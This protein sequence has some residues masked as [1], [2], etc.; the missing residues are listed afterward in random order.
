MT[1]SPTIYLIL[2][3]LPIL[4]LL[5]TMAETSAT[6]LDAII[7]STR[8]YEE[9]L[10]KPSLMGAGYGALMNF[11]AEP[12]LSSATYVVDDGNDKDHSINVYKIPL[13]HDF[14]LN[15]YGMGSFIEGRLGYL[16]MN[17]DYFLV[18]KE[19]SL[20]IVGSKWE[21]C[22]GT[23]GGGLSFPMGAGFSFIP[24]IYGGIAYLKNSSSYHGELANVFLKPVFD[25]LG[26]NWNTSATLLNGIATIQYADTIDTFLLN[27]E[28][29]Y[30]FDYIDTFN[31][32]SSYQKFVTDSSVITFKANLSHPLGFAV[33]G[34]PLSWVIHAGNSTFIGANRNVMGFNYFNELGFSIKADTAQ[35]KWSVQNISLGFM[36][37][38]GNNIQGWSILFGY[39][40]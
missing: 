10:L 1:F 21:T 3:F 13:R 39:S 32:S 24:A 38:L 7:A 8:A 16:K 22:S 35:K 30:S 27:G 25:G 15:Q 28:L 26:F 23:L 12:A 5:C 31:E 6:E 33:S 18:E 2:P 29:S 14:D 40:F 9:K 17:I 20:K 37:I 36:G 4:I 11:S 34:L 19:Q